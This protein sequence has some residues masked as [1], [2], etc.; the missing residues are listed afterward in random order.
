MMV[1]SFTP[2]RIGIMTSV[3]S[4][5]AEG[6][7]GAAGVCASGTVS[8]ARAPMITSA[9]H[10]ARRVIMAARNE[11]M[12]ADF[13]R[14]F[15]YTNSTGTSYAPG[16]APERPL[17]VRAR[18]VTG[19]FAAFLFA[20]GAGTRL[21]RLDART[22]PGASGHWGPCSSKLRCPAVSGAQRA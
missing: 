16:R 22:R 14:Q 12:G 19:S 9:A 10:L 1:Y 15:W 2:S 3:L 18:L 8:G 7:A 17:R 11:S 20:H 21:R 13:G 4:N 5:A 6:S